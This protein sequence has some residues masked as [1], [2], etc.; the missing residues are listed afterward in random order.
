MHSSYLY[1]FSCWLW[2]GFSFVLS[3]KVCDGLQSDFLIAIRWRT[4]FSSLFKFL[5]I[6]VWSRKNAN[7][8]LQTKNNVCTKIALCACLLSM[9]T[10]KIPDFYLFFL[11]F[12]T[13][14]PSIMS[15]L[16]FYSLFKY[17]FIHEPA[18]GLFDDIASTLFMLNDLF[19]QPFIL[20]TF[21]AYFF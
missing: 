5:S 11:C 3:F 14:S 6:S 20:I 9:L 1:A 2:A 7:R 18:Y 4:F 16:Y 17:L 12:R 21:S 8:A 13:S 10:I 15:L 19:I